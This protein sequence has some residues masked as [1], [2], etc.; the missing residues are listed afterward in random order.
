MRTKPEEDYA[1]YLAQLRNLPFVDEVHIEELEP[2]RP[3]PPR[4]A[5]HWDA[6]L[7]MRV[8]GRRHHFLVE[9]KRAPRLNFAVVDALVGGVERRPRER[10][11]L[12]TPYVT[13]QIAAEL[14]AREV[15]YIDRA[16]NCRLVVDKGHIAVIEGR[17]LPPQLTEA[18]ATGPGRYRVLFA[19]LARPDTLRMTVRDIA[20]KAGVGKTIAAL[21]LQHLEQEGLIAQAR[22][23]TFLVKPKE[24]LDRWLTGYLEILRPKLLI[25]FYRAAEKDPIELERRIEQALEFPGETQRAMKQTDDWVGGKKKWAWG[26]TTA[27][28]RLTGHYRG[29]QTVLHMDQPPTDLARRLQLLPARAGELAVIATPGPLAYEGAIPKTVHPILVYAELLAGRDDRAREAAAEVRTQFLRY[30]E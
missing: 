11:I 7:D 9:Y 19:L 30:L 24:L 21:T 20:R 3:G 12:L 18:R 16:G 28:F 22:T 5:V 1:P 23:N 8:A 13:P 14:Q 4:G 6:L 25:G 27:A 2:R 26:G 10:W 15:N 29:E 17:R